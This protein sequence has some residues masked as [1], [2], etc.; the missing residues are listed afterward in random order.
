MMPNITRGDRMGSLMGYLVGAG[1]SNEH[2]EP[3]LVAGD[4]AIMAWYGDQILS[5]EDALK[6][7]EDLDEPRRAFGTSVTVPDKVAG[8]RKD[9]HVWHCSLAIH[10]DDGQLTEGQWADIAT[11]FAERMGWTEESGRTPAR[12]VAVHHG[13]SKKGNDH[14]HFAVSLVRE[15]G[16]KVDVHNDFRRAQEFAGE[17]EE[18]Y[19][20]TAPAARAAGMGSRGEKPA[21]RAT[22]ERRGDV[23]V[24]RV[25]LA[26]GVRAAA[27]ASADE[28]EFVRRVRRSGLL[29]RPRFASGRNDVVEGYSVA[30]RPPDGYPV[31]WYGGGKLD[32]D[33]T[34]KR[35][36][37]DW[38]DTPET[39]QVAVDEWQA[40]YR[41]NRPAAPGRETAE[42]DPDLW[43]TYSDDVARLREQLR[44]VP[45]SDR[46]TWAH[47][48]RETAGAFAAWSERVESTPGPLAAAAAELAKSAQLR[49]HEVKPKAT[50]MPSA[51]GAALLLASVALRGQGTIAQ[52]IMLRQLMNTT[53]AIY[54]GMVARNDSRRAEDLARVVREQLKTVESRLP[55]VPSVSVEERAA[56]E[57]ARFG[58][59]GFGPTNTTGSP[60]PTKLSTTR[61]TLPATPAPGRDIER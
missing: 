51:R 24:A 26:R 27:A 20:L 1:R 45:V 33:L 13:V 36:R 2:T 14:I 39:A 35:L 29:I 16:T 47:V 9:A 15:D 44:S 42:P 18:K 43:K 22:A 34:I 57:A 49:A 31:V 50:S 32:R 8:G 23:E 3:H 52:A 28:G 10:A 19:G 60:V 54:D 40:A 30:L 21:E 6:I 12:W 5:R 48:A 46:A 38:P 11:A 58:R 4:P 61:P 59:G 7:A 56:V 41:G 25:R 55:A 17:M 53:K 37:A